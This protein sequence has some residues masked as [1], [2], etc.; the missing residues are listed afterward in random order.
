VD[1]GGGTVAGVLRD[2]TARL[3]AAGSRS[4][5]LDAE[6]LL[7]A[8]LG[9]ER[10]D[11]FRA[12]E[13]A[14]TGEERARFNGFIRRREAREPVAYIRGRRGFRT[15]DL[16]V[17]P[18]VLIPRPETETLVDVALELLAAMPQ[19]DGAA[20]EVLDV[21]TGSGCIA[22][23]L[24]AENPF[25]RV[26]AVDID[27]EA[28]AVARRNAARHGLERRVGFARG[29][30]CDDLPPEPRFDLVVS[31]PPYVPADEYAALEPNVRDFEPRA[32][33]YGGEDGLDAY[34]RLIPAAARRLRPGG[35]LAVE[36]GAGEAVA[37][38]ALFA[39]AGV[40]CEAEER[41]DLA[42]IPRVVFARRPALTGP[43]GARPPRRD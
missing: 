16:E 1:S 36:V 29:D 7:A 26:L 32:A 41:A 17:T 37:V 38:R 15:L 30:L 2:A 6:L 14:L 21:G 9:G 39:A 23:A 27:E 34:R 3:R 19:G 28:L 33:L 4:P 40:F 12:P 43:D 18:A 25:V 24:A 35:A 20:L 10:L 42:G 22:L 5:R 8:A 11:L 31:N 13:R